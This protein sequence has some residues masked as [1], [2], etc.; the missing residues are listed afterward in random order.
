MWGS[1][2]GVGARTKISVFFYLGGDA[3][4]PACWLCLGRAPVLLATPGYCRNGLGQ[5][6]V[7]NCLTACC[8]PV[9][10][11]SIP[12]LTPRLL[13]RGQ[14]FLVNLEYV[15]DDFRFRRNSNLADISGLA[16]IASEGHI[17][18]A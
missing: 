5:A 6:T 16:K 1:V 15:G 3:G 14:D 13:F 18:G 9:G 8:L 7:G 4:L 10:V 12:S 17:A 2:G 11:F